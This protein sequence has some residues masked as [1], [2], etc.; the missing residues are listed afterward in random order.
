MLNQDI[1]DFLVRSRQCEIEGLEH[2]L[3]T[4]IMVGR[5]R[6]LIHGL[7]RER[8]ATNLFLGSR[9]QCYAE[10]MIEYRR[11]AGIAE[12]EVRAHLVG[13]LER[14]RCHT[15]ASRFFAHVALALH[16]LGELSRLREKVDRFEISAPE[17]MERF[18]DLVRHLLAVVF[19]AAD[20]VSDPAISSALVAL[21][22]FMQ[23]KELAGQERAVGVAGFGLGWREEALR[24]ALMH[25]IDAQERC[26][27]IFSE[28]ADAATLIRWQ[29]LS[30]S[31]LTAEVER[32]RRMAFT[33]TLQGDSGFELAQI[34]FD[35]ATR[36]I[37]AMKSI[38]DDLEQVLH[39][40]CETR[41]VRAHA[42]WVD[43]EARIAELARE[44]GASL[45]VGVILGYPVDAAAS[46]VLLDVERQHVMG[47]GVGRSLIEL[48]QMQSRRLQSVED[49][50][51]AAR[52]AL[53][54]RKLIEQAKALL[55][56]HRGMTEDEAYRVLRKAAMDQGKRLIE[57]AR[58]AIAMAEVLGPKF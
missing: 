48:V 11:E 17:A 32:L 28:F 8:G 44:G 50:L 35:Q 57:V 19:E 30:A 2:L 18:N 55:I 27:Q 42:E 34:W 22:N 9:G 4:S 46:G 58:A 10:R 26:F 53:E 16:G 23:G 33:R 43:D 12:G 1:A 36:R 54:E 15:A 31:P 29:Q 3:A 47:G 21:L 39:D 5:I 41:L 40:L 52:E 38:E 37:D 24:E 51:R 14:P 49:E 20:P 13:W 45:P 6:A 7:Q 56:K 25:R